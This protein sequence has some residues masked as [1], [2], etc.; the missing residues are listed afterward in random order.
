MNPRDR[1]V[2]EI[3]ELVTKWKAREES[4]V[5]GVWVFAY[6]A[7]VGVNTAP[8]DVRQEALDAVGDGLREGAV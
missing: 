5:D 4:P 6:A 2:E 3:L 7:G 8:P 1:M